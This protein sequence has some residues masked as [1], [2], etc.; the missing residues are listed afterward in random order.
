MPHYCKKNMGFLGIIIPH[1]QSEVQHRPASGAR[2][3]P[4]RRRRAGVEG[5]SGQGPGFHAEYGGCPFES[6][7]MTEPSATP[8]CGVASRLL[9]QNHEAPSF[10]AQLSPVVPN[11]TDCLLFADWTCGDCRC[12]PVAEMDTRRSRPIHYAAGCSATI[13]RQP[14]PSGVSHR[15]ET[16]GTAGSLFFPKT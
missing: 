5:F 8:F 6:E 16:S 4:E 12:G 3:W 9:R 7:T 15:S 13:D 14:A 11:G 2:A 10:S 1:F